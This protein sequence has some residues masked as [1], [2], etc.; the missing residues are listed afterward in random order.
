MR[1]IFLFLPKK[2]WA[3]AQP[4]KNPRHCQLK[5]IIWWP[6]KDSGF[7]KWSLSFT[8]ISLN[9]W[10][11]KSHF[12]VI[13]HR[14]LKNLDFPNPSKTHSANFG[15]WFIC[16]GNRNQ[17]INFDKWWAI[18]F[19]GEY[20]EHGLSMYI[21]YTCKRIKKIKPEAIS[22]ISSNNMICVLILKYK[23]NQINLKFVIRKKVHLISRTLNQLS[24]ILA[25]WQQENFCTLLYNFLL[26]FHLTN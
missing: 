7:V 6:A 10:T 2:T 3:L 25:K 1:R 23:K 15:F 20:V 21:L 5:A 16:W 22:S 13:I 24:L 4:G 26:I 19:D 14:E 18:I 17:Q 11:C 12:Q 8:L 9:G